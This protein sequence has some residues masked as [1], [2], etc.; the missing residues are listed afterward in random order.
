MLFSSVG[1]RD[2]VGMLLSIACRYD[3]LEELMADEAT[4][5]VTL[6]GL[7]EQLPK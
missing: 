4:L 3:C 6:G 7:M 1:C 5:A 2:D